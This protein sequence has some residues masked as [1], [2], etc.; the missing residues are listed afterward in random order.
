MIKALFCGVSNYDFNSNLEY[1]NNDSKV[2]AKAFI[3]NIQIEK[4]NIILATE[5]GKIT[6]FKYMR[7]LKEFCINTNEDDLIVVYFSGHGG[8]DENGNSI[9][10]ATNS[11]NESTYIYINQVIDEI[12]NAAAKSALVILDC[13]HSD[14]MYEDNNSNILDIDKTIERFYGAGISILSSCKRNE[15]S[16]PDIDGKISAFTSFLCSALSSNYGADKI[17]YLNELKNLI[18]IYAKVWGRKHPNMIQTPVLRSNII[19]NIIFPKR[20]YKEVVKK[21]LGIDIKNDKFDIINLEFYRKK[22][23]DIEVKYYQAKIM[24][25]MPINDDNIEEIL[26]KIFLKIRN[27]KLKAESWQQKRVEDNP[28]EVINV[29]IGNDKIDIEDKFWEYRAVWALKDKEYWLNTLGTNS[30]KSSEYS[31]I[32]NK[33]YNDLKNNRLENTYTDDEM[34]DF[35]DEKIKI[36]VKNIEEIIRCYEEYQRSEKRLSDIIEL[37]KRKNIEL[38][39]D[40]NQIHNLKFTIPGSII[41]DLDKASMKLADTIEGIIFYCYNIDIDKE[42]NFNYCFN[43][44]LSNYYREFREWC[45][46]KN[47]IKQLIFN[48]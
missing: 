10:S 2:L 9:L 20:K 41:R 32:R 45:E 19:G 27:V 21:E 46:I 35:W 12:T 48:E 29:F 4:E 5:N 14:T 18:D 47:K 43:I 44:E 38:I 33:Q 26:N 6:N 7:I 37:A 31:Y 30:I 15:K 1:C 28:V 24:M 39:N 22:H 17:L 13:C 23:D 16:Y 25:K 36:L 42:I 34:L 3:D 8:V 40:F 11:C